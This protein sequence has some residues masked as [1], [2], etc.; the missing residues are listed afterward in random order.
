MIESNYISE[1]MQVGAERLADDEGCADP[2]QQPAGAKSSSEQAMS[3]PALQSPASAG[4]TQIQQARRGVAN[5]I[6]PVCLRVGNQGATPRTIG[7][8]S[9]PRKLMLVACQHMRV[10]VQ[11]RGR[12]RAP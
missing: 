10:A 3:T 5:N 7:H 12:A 1:F 9:F 11:C 4:Q 2:V 6:R 8:T